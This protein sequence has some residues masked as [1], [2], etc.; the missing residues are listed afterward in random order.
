[1]WIGGRRFSIPHSSVTAE[2]VTNDMLVDGVVQLWT[3][4]VASH[5]LFYSRHASKSIFEFR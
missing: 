1:M 4:Y 3:F 2:L 5:L